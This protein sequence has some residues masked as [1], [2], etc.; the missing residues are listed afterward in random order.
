MRLRKAALLILMTIPAFAQAPPAYPPQELDRLVSR[1][2]LYPDPL[3]A[4]T[5]AAATFSD[6]IPDAAR[7]SDEHHYLTGDALAQAIQGDQLPWDPSVQGL[8]PF[9]PVLGLIGFYIMCVHQ[10]RYV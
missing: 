1:I 5:L 8:F 2:A 4:Q 9:S 10:T 3:L 6:Q 7:W